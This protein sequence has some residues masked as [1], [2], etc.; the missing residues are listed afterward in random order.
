MSK[1]IKLVTP[2]PGLKSQALMLE[3]QK[4]VA[5]GPFHTTPIFAAKA[6]GALLEDVDGNKKDIKIELTII[7]SKILW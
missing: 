6:H 4:N 3:R 7:Q 5:R 1:A 2:V